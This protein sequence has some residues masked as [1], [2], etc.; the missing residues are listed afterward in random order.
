MRLRNMLLVFEDLIERGFPL[1]PDAPNR[2]EDFL[3][4]EDEDDPYVDSYY[5]KSVSPGEKKYVLDCEMIETTFGDE[6]A[7][8]TLID[9]NENV[10]IDKLI[11]PRGRIIDTRY[12]ITGIEESDLLESDY[13]L[14][15]IQKLIL[16][17]FLDA[18]HIL[19]GHALHNDLKVLKLRH[20]RII[21]TQDL[22]Q[23]IYQLSYVPSLR[24]LA[25]KFLHESIQN[26]GHDSVEDALATLHLVKRFERN[27]KLRY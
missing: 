21:D 12:H 5:D 7:R 27:I 19:I 26:N 15:R 20:P 13:T 18:N 23:H 1:H 9:W 10:C 22:Y 25:W 6:V 2:P 17:I 11:R 24:S 16:D 8:V 4:S 3:D 14:Q